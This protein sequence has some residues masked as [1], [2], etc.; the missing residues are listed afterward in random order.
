LP[1]QPSGNNGPNQT[2]VTRIGVGLLERAIGAINPCADFKSLW[3][4]AAQAVLPDPQRALETAADQQSRQHP[5]QAV[6]TLRVHN[7][8]D[9]Q[10]HLDPLDQFREGILKRRRP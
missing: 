7:H 1:N 9:D 10:D 5:A 4:D 3:A 8:E 6:P 2:E